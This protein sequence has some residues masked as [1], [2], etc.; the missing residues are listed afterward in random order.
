MV[1][2]DD[3]GLKMGSVEEVEILEKE[4]NDLHVVEE[5][6]GEFFLENKKLA[7]SNGED[8]D[9]K[10][11]QRGVFSTRMHDEVGDEEEHRGIFSIGS[12]NE[13]EMR[14][15]DEVGDEEE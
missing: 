5:R 3:E 9:E 4:R 1:L 14:L 13:S 11:E 10:E 6:E 15:Q 8:D 7:V 12:G 2:N